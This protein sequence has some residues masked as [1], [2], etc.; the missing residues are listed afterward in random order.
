MERL[1]CLQFRQVLIPFVL[2]KTVNFSATWPSVFNVLDYEWDFGDPTS[3]NNLSTSSN[4]A[5]TYAD[6]GTYLVQLQTESPC[7]GW[8]KI[9]TFYV[10]V[11]PNINP[12]VFITVSAAEIC[13][14]ETVSF[15]AVPYFGGPNPAYEWFHNNASSGNGPSY[16]PAAIVD[17]DEVYVQMVSFLPVP[18]KC[19]SKF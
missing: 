5:H 11:I 4:P 10:E 13:E 3:G 18:P 19:P 6:V 16:T 17:G 1:S 12:E 9:D 7:C 15:G 2:A 14:G 8:S